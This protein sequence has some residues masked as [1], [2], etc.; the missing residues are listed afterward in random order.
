MKREV[1][2]D[3]AYYVCHDGRQLR[4]IRT[5]KKHQDGYEQTIEV[6]PSSA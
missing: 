3:E 5:E 6:Y 2:E 1:F 4:H